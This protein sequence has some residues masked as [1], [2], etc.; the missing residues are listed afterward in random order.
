M[1]LQGSSRRHR[2]RASTRR[3]IGRGSGSRPRQDLRPRPQGPGPALR[4]RRRLRFEGGQMPLYRRLP[5]RGFTQRTLPRR[6]HRR[7][8]R[9]TSTR[10]ADGDDGRPRTVLAARARRPEE[11]RAPQ[12]ARQRRAR[13]RAHGARAH[14]QR[15]RA[16]KIEKAGGTVD[17]ARPAGP[18][19]AAAAE[20]QRAS[21]R[22]EVPQPL[23]RSP[24]SRKRILITLGLLLS[25]TGVGFHVPI[26]GVEPARSCSELA[27]A[28]DQRTRLRGS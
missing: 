19:A 14:V 18:K 7:Q 21:D 20:P 23:P 6:L 17:R 10:F 13:G 24:R 9:A 25:S 1:N 11:R 8:R 22:A 3:R 2:S 26:P 15:R 27:R 28:E 4:A 16:E 12:G 5:K